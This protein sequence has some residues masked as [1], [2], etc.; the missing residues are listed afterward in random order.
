LSVMILL[1]LFNFNVLLGSLVQGLPMNKGI[2][3]HPLRQL[4]DQ[5]LQY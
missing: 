4:P 3:T 5:C 2:A 1:I